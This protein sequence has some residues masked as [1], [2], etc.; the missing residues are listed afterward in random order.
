MLQAPRLASR[1][2]SFNAHKHAVADVVER[3]NDA[4]AAP[5]HAHEAGA[6]LETIFQVDVNHT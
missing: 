2:T 3:N 1:A 5:E 4:T 6:A